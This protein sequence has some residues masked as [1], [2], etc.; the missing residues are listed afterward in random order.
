MD[1]GFYPVKERLESGTKEA[2]NEVFLVDVGGGI[3]HDLQEL[4]KKHPDLSGRLILQDQPN[5]IDQIG[6][7]LDGIELTVH[8][9]FTSQPVKGK[10]GFSLA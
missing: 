4:K 9:F 8:D 2:K 5:V 3:G 7:S 10:L 6:Q 1:K